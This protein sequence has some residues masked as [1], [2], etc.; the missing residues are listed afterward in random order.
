MADSETS[1]PHTPPSVTKPPAVQY[2]TGK[3]V[4]LS[5]VKRALQYE[6]P[7]P[8]DASQTVL[9]RT[10]RVDHEEAGLLPVRD[11]NTMLACR[12]VAN[13][14]SEKVLVVPD[15]NTM[16]TSQSIPDVVSKELLP[17][18]DDPTI[19]PDLAVVPTPEKTAGS[20]R[21]PLAQKLDGPGRK[22]K[23]T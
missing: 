20:K 10:S 5:N 19:P 18:A 21:R 15:E 17:I 6:D 12:S 3:A 16:A 4:V 14:D 23:S 8:V 13:T 1:L 9:E 22:K 2:I 11:A 7:S